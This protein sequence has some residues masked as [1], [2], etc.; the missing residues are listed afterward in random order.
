MELRHLRYFM[1]VAEELHFGKA[2]LRLQMTQPPLSQQIKQ[3]ENEIGVTLLKR[4]KRAV[5]LTAAGGVFLKQIKEGLSQI[6]QAVDMA[7]RTARGELGRLVIGFVGSATFEIMP[8]IIREYRNQ[9]PS[10]KIELRELSTPNQVKALLNGHI[11]IG[12]LH[13]PLGNDELI[14]NTVKKSHCVL[15]LPKQHPLTKKTRVDLKDL[16]EESLIVIAKE[17]WPSL[18]TEFNFLCEKA[19]FI[20]N[21]AQEATE[22]QMVIGLVSAGMGIAV[23]PTAAK[24]LFNLDVVYK[25]IEDLPLRAEWVTAYRKDNRN[26][27]LRHF[28]DVSNHR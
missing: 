14:T 28:L 13:P 25:E 1:V 24:R 18:Y 8:P 17:S 6:D 27:A 11:D 3:L 5:R 26:P 2:A 19:G 9:F 4:S 21:I 22:Y 16:E 10:V 7:Q 20:P 23:V 12:V 15:A